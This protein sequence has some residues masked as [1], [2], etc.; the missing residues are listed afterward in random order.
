MTLP[1]FDI[2]GTQA[3][4]VGAGRGIGRW[5]ALLLAEAGADVAVVSL[6]SGGVDRVVSE[7]REMG[8]KA[9]GVTADATK[10]KD[11]D[12]VAQQVLPQ[13]PNLDVLVNCVGDSIRK[14]VVPL[15]GGNAQGMSEADWHFV[16]DVNLTE[17]FH[18][19]RAFGPH[20][21]KRRRGSVI[22][23]SGIMGFRGE[24]NL[25]AYSAAKGGLTQFTQALAKEWAPYSIRVNAIAPG[26]FPDQEQITPETL[27]QREREAAG[28]IPLGRLGGWRDIGMLAVFLAS[29]A[30]AYV[31]GQTWAVDGGASIAGPGP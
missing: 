11:M 12:R 3:L 28:R 15:P 18:G 10:G 7:I 6:S 13:F 31:T 24:A 22:N 19:C 21:L 27:R 30:S 4:V 2:E 5:I 8:R 16:V 23:I 29:P 1:E 20:L 9:V 26:S 17:A 25:T 14:P